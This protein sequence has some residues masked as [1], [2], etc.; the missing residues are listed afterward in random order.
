MKPLARLT[1][2]GFTDDSLDGNLSDNTLC[3]DTAEAQALIRPFT[4]Y[5]CREEKPQ[6]QYSGLFTFNGGALCHDCFDSFTLERGE[7]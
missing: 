7:A 3:Q 5:Q 6:S 2:R 1:A 4:R